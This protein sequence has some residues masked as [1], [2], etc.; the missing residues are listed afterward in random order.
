MGRGSVAAGISAGVLVLTVAAPAHAERPAHAGERRAI[1]RLAYHACVRSGD[2]RCQKANVEVSTVNTHWAFGGAFGD[3]ESGWLVHKINGHWQVRAVFG[4]GVPSC[5]SIT[6]LAPHHVLKDLHLFFG[7]SPLHGN[8][9][10]CTHAA[11]TLFEDLSGPRYKPRAFCPANHTCFSHTK[12]SK[13]TR[14]AA[15]GHGL[16]H[17]SSSTGSGSRTYRTKIE[18]RRPKHICAARAF[19]RAKWSDGATS[20]YPD[21]QGCGSWN[22]G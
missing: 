22:G 16:A 21:G 15:V 13:W 12:W 11:A 10:S 8:G 19:T 17:Y 2:P 4:S 7:T 1:Q 3:G 14:D 18:F 5:S 6:N 20:F 9:G